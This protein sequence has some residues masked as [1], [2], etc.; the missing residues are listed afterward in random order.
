MFKLF[1]S[2]ILLTT[3]DS[4]GRYTSRRVSMSSNTAQ[5]MRDEDEI[6]SSPELTP[7]ATFNKPK[8]VKKKSKAKRSGDGRS[9]NS[10]TLQ[11]SRD[12][13]TPQSTN[14][15]ELG[16]DAMDGIVGSM[17][18]SPQQGFKTPE[19]PIANYRSPASSYASSPGLAARGANLSGSGGLSTRASHSGRTMTSS[20]SAASPSVQSSLAAASLAHANLS[21]MRRAIAS[22][23]DHSARAPPSADP[24]P[25]LHDY[26]VDYVARNMELMRM[27]KEQ[28][29]KIKEA[30]KSFLESPM[31]ASPNTDYP[32]FSPRLSSEV[33]SGWSSSSQSSSG[34]SQNE[35]GAVKTR[36]T[37]A[38]IH[39]NMAKLLD[40]D[41]PISDRDFAAMHYQNGERPSA[42]ALRDTLGSLKDMFESLKPAV[43]KQHTASQFL[44]QRAESSAY[45]QR[46]GEKPPTYA[47]TGPEDTKTKPA[48]KPTRVEKAAAKAVKE[49]DQAN[50]DYDEAFERNLRG[51]FE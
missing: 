17:G 49:F 50:K 32:L 44:Q 9:M 6:P 41:D 51:M 42:Q 1:I 24:P 18:N 8:K 3:I 45:A 38:D 28:V 25:V 11:P 15:M 14:N 23:G 10:P 36:E 20:G 35:A 12:G 46:Q 26:Q 43:N 27:M 37:L 30:Q 7:Q 4:N 33:L 19:T 31:S 16:F 34:Q 5:S 21:S 2:N 13:H 48:E 39:R 29:E 47:Y 22:S 40:D